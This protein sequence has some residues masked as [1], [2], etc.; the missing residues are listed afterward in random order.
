MAAA[1]SGGASNMTMTTTMTKPPVVPPRAPN[2]DSRD[3]ATGPIVPT[4]GE[5][6]YTLKVHGGQTVDATPFD[7]GNGTALDIYEQFYFST[8]WPAGT[9]ATIYGTDVDNAQ[10]LHHWVL[11]S[12]IEKQTEGAHIQ[13]A[14]P[15]L[16]G[17]DPQLVAAWTL[18]GPNLAVPTNVGLELP[19][20]GRTLD[21]Q[22]HYANRTGTAQH[23]ASS[24]QICTVPA[25]QRAHIAT[26]T[27]LGTEDLNGNVWQNGAGM[28]PHK[29]STFS[30]TCLPA[31]RGLDADAAI[32]LIGFMP[33]MHRIGTH[34]NTRVQRASGEVEILF[35]AAFSFGHGRHNVVHF[36]LNANESLTTTCTYNNTNDYGVSFGET[37]NDEMCYQFVLAYPARALGNAASSLLGWTDTCW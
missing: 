34:M 9:V 10:V 24:V 27:A 15:T 32:Q 19:A 28:P 25:N 17:T 30:G 3:G 18:G 26:F 1:G 16:I 8:P 20:P 5:T 29:E 4:S 2:D 13:T 31:R 14:L 22:V 21:L 12:T 36:E 6:C 11:F 33:H 23:D 7:V 37:A 35:D